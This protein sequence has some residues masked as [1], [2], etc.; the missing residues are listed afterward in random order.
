VT[1][2]ILTECTDRTASVTQWRHFQRPRPELAGLDPVELLARTAGLPGVLRYG[3]AGRE[4]LLVG[5]VRAAPGADIEAIIAELESR[6]Q[7]DLA[8]RIEGVLAE[9]VVNTTL[10][11]TGLGWKRRETGW[12]LPAG[13]SLPREIHL[14]AEGDGLRVEAILV[15]WDE[16]GE[17]EVQ[18]ITHL[19]CR[20]QLGLRFA[21]CRLQPGQAAVVAHIDAQHL[22]EAL[23]DAV[24]G[25]AAGTRLL[26]REVAALLEPG[27]ARA[28]LDFLATAKKLGLART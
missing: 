22:G 12:A 21:R 13:A 11:E 18:A 1:T 9:E 17:A 19:L 25:V 16:A 24:G 6:S 26:A 7:G 4:V 28:F 27:A 15:E 2:A 20:A 3:T 23:A 5:E 14:T 10:E 8:G